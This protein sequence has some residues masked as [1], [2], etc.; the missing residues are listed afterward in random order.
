MWK[1]ILKEE[2]AAY[3]IIGQIWDIGK[4]IWAKDHNAVFALIRNTKWPNTIEPY[5]C[6]LE[7]VYRQKSLQLIGKNILY[8]KPL[9]SGS[10]MTKLK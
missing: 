2:K 6:H 8:Q 7:E 9:N 4:K 1:R 10:Q 5:M 3:P